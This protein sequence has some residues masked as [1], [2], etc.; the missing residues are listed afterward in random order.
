MP[1]RQNDEPSA[2]RKT[3]VVIVRPH[4]SSDPSCPQYEQYCQQKL[5]LHRPFREYQQ[6]KADFDTFAEAFAD[7]LQSDTIPQ[8]LDDDIR[9]LQQQQQQAQEEEPVNEDNDDQN[10][11]LH[12]RE[13]WVLL[14]S[15]Q[16]HSDNDDEAGSSTDWAAV[17]QLYPNLEEAPRFVTRLKETTELQPTTSTAEPQRLQGKQQLVYQAVQHQIDAEDSETLLMIVSGTAGTGKFFKFTV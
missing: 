11:P 8:S 17:A 15:N 4:C 13:E 5:M 3:V 6:L 12:H 2:R 10:Q 1:N 9:R 16:Q 7:F 14:C